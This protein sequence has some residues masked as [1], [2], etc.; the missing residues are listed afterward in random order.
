MA[1][2]NRQ[3]AEGL[4]LRGV[5][6]QRRGLRAQHDLARLG[7]RLQARRDADHVSGD[8][9]PAPRSVCG[10]HLAALESQMEVEPDAELGV[11]LVRKRAQLV[12]EL[13][14]C[15]GCAECVVLAGDRRTLW[16]GQQGALVLTREVR[17]PEEGVGGLGDRPEIGL[18]LRRGEGGCDPATRRAAG[19]ALNLVIVPA[20]DGDSDALLGTTGLLRPVWEHRVVEIGYFVAPHARGHG[21]ATRA[22]KLLA[23]WALTAVGFQRVTADIDVEN[24][25]SQ[26]VAERA[27]F[28]REG[29]L[30]RYRRRHGVREDL[31]M[32]SLLAED[33][34]A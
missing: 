2:A 31:V 25:G 12:A 5:R 14:G 18:R 17:G 23:P 3:L 13:E 32:F 20:T 27:G 34:R 7:R 9:H 6:N 29:T 33:V 19:E 26:R 15:A 28:T 22:V 24:T 21:Y 1:A 11:E 8:E 4:Q 30:R 10:H 16:I